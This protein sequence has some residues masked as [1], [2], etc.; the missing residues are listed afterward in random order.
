MMGQ[1]I[2]D[3]GQPNRDAGNSIFLA[4]H[5][6]DGITKHSDMTQLDCDHLGFL[7]LQLITPKSPLYSA[8]VEEAVQIAPFPDPFWG[9][10]WPG[11]YAICRY[12]LSN[13]EVVRD[14]L[15]LD[16]AA[17]C[18]IASIV[19][20]QV[21]AASC[22]ANDIDPWACSASLIN[23]AANLSPSAFTSLFNVHDGNLVGSTLTSIH[24]TMRHHASVPH[25]PVPSDWVVLAGDVCYEEPLASNVIQWLR[26][27]A[28]QG[29]NVLIGDP[30]RQFLPQSRL[31][32]VASYELPPTIADGNFG[33]QP[34]GVVW[35]TQHDSATPLK[36][37]LKSVN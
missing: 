13:R 8:S 22:I 4:P 2:A 25:D 1:Q 10:C 21:G 34:N 18:G 36:D 14:K 23:A 27:L 17:G 30:G 6:V 9:F 7:R 12:I 15:V 37:P 35:T 3:E 32:P 31:R 24:A 20:L 33:L 16:F 29:V 11:S 28:G 19:A 26:A 5:Y